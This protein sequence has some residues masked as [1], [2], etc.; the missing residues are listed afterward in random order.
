MPF[1]FLNLEKLICQYLR[2]LRDFFGGNALVVHVREY[3]T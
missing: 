3:I 1:I 2:V